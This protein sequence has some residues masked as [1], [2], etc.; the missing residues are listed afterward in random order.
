M[1]REEPSHISVYRNI[2]AMGRKPMAFFLVSHK[3]QKQSA[4]KFDERTIPGAKRRG[5]D[6]FVLGI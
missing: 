2:N 5:I 1:G 4:L 6:G 3:L